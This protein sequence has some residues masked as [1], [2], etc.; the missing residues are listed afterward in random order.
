ML[1]NETT[2]KKAVALKY[3]INE[4][5]AP[6]V[7]AKGQG[8]I[9]EKIIQIAHKNNIPIKKDKDLLEILSKVD[10][11]QEIPFELYKVVAEILVYVYK[12]N[13]KLLNFKA[14]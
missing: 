1:K 8:L 11:M 6:R 7:V 13:N 14:S 9:A 4:D 10:V 5:S 12:I 2:L 3:K